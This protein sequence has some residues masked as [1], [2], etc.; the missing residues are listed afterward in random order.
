[1]ITITQ[2]EV[3]LLV[4]DINSFA[5]YAERMLRSTQAKYNDE[6]AG[7]KLRQDNELSILKSSYENACFS[8]KSKSKRTIN[9]AYKILT[10]ISSLDEKLSE[11]DKY[12]VKTKKKKKE[13]LSDETSSEYDVATDYFSALK[14]IKESFDLLFKKYSED[15]LPGLVNGL[16]YIFSSHRKKDYEELIILQNTLKV[17]IQEIEKELPSITEENLS[18][19]KGDYL[20]KRSSL[21]ERHTNEKEDYEKE[22]IITL[23]NVAGQIYDE[24]DKIIPDEF[25]DYL[26]V[27]I[28]KYNKNI[29][30]VNSSTDV[31]DGVFNMMFVDYPVDFFVQ[32]QI[33]SSVIKEKCSKLLVNGAIRLP[34]A[35]SIQDMP[36][37]M[38]VNDNSNQTVVQQFIH[39]VMFNFLSA[40]PVAEVIYSIVDPENRGNSVSAFFDA[41]KK[42]PELFGEKI[43][44]SRDDI[45]AKIAKINEYIENTLQ[46]KLGNQFDNI[47]D[48]AKEHMGFTF[49]AELLIL[50]DFP[51]GFEESTLGELRNIIK[52]GNRCGVYTIISYLPDTDSSRSREY[53]Q[54]INSIIEITTQIVQKDQNLIMKGLPLTYYTMPEKNDFAEFIS[55][56]MLIFEGIK[57]KGIVF[58][59]L[60]KKLVDARDS[61]E[62]EEHIKY[63]CEMMQVYDKNYLR[64][65]VDE[66][67][68]PYYVSLGSAL[69]PSD[70]FSDSIGYQIIIDKFG[71]G[72]FKDE[73]IGYVE[74]PLTFDLRNSFNLFLNCSDISKQSMLKFT[75]HVIWSMLSL[76]PVTKVNI[77]VF[78]AEQR[79][80]SIIPFL[81][82]RKKCPEIFD[83][84][85]YTSLDMMTDR[86]QKINIQIDE[87]IQDKLG[88]KYKDILD[89]NINNPNCSESVTLLV[90]FDFPSGLNGQSLDFLSGIVRNGNKCGVF[91]IICYNPNIAISKYENIDMR[92]ENITRCCAIIGY[93]EGNYRLL[94]Y[95]LQINIPTKMDNSSI[96][97]F[98]KDYFEKSEIVKKQGLLFKD[99]LSYNLFSLSSA[100][101]LCVPI[102][103]GVGNEIVEIKIG[104]GASHHGLIAGATGSGKS[105]LLHTFIMSCMLHYTPDELQLYLMDFKGGT[106]FK[107]YESARLPHL[108]LLALDAM[109][110]FGESILEN[111]VQE[112]EDR[113]NA[114]KGDGEKGE[115]SVSKLKDYITAR[116]KSMPRIV[117]IMDEFQILFNDSTNRKV[118]MHCAELTKRIVTE[119]R[120]YGIHLFMATQS[121]RI[122]SDLTISSGTLEQ[123]RIRIGLKCGENDARYLFTDAKDSDAL[124]K[125]KG[126]IGT[127]VINLD[128]TEQSN[129]GFRVAYCS[130]EEQRHYLSVIGETF[131]DKPFNLQIFEG[132][133]TEKLLDYYEMSGIGR[134]TEA[135]VNI[136]LGTLIKVAPPFAITIDKKK[137]HNLLVCGANERM[138]NMVSNN[139]M[140]SV[141]LN[142]NTSI[143]CIDGDRL[144][145]DDVSQD[146]YAEFLETTHRFKV[147]EDRGDIIR[148]IGDVYEKY[149]E[150]RNK[151]SN[152]IIFVVIKNLQFLDI[153]K[154]MLKGEMFDESEYIDGDTVVENVSS[155]NPFAAVGNMINI[156]RANDNFSVSKKLVKLID[157]GSSFGIHFLVTSLEYSTVRETMYYGE[158]VLTKFPERIIFSLSQNDANNLIDNISVD[159]LRDN[160]V[161]FTDSV[162]NTFQMKPYIA[163][164]AGVLRD[165]LKT[166]GII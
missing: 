144:V 42:L 118:A 159:S 74:L 11:V 67:K 91:V 45:I 20:F 113:S 86:L 107:I 34:V 154:T 137:K 13:A 61:I 150:W 165:Y 62:L 143:Y 65:P 57:N 1:M 88:N 72:E 8:V 85:I 37:W 26:Y 138:A 63:I 122:I 66:I 81:D 82:F 109:Q 146:I 151:R 152:E 73:Q 3:F 99:I 29:Y 124:S 51:K 129:I 111:L 16:N 96:E 41:K 35:M 116:G 119:G 166:N 145:G 164:T 126:P 92:I 60:I 100:D 110:E 112:I 139:Y 117:I 142:E 70:I 38:V 27:L 5:D 71:V 95:N 148:F 59:P 93:K 147:A 31:I 12:Y 58:S 76:M 162:K 46:D 2:N 127:A 103:V 136:H 36:V 115:V 33:V 131:K 83:Q 64:I 24:L 44:I 6:K 32:S 28:H 49:H 22:Y 157:D 134:T 77:C 23:D 43:L 25:V 101:S 155:T 133:R 121:T 108:R 89:Y 123:M 135:A 160:T 75:H 158:N 47:F 163:P 104:E 17:F 40:I 19:L 132:K 52:N 56:Y 21:I 80:N 78:D 48:Y 106:E 87:F 97:A 54:N 156:R 50:F 79:G 149:Q 14:K 4:S 53:E 90:L 9:D 125:M 128:Y 114:F 140:I 30:K 39:S 120:S 10:Q 69:Y 55:R 98:V 161:Y 18:L 94:P 84:K 7:L 102:G 141:L 153:V 105:T 15:I 68:F 130:N